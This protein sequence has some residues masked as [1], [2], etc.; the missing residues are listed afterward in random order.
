MY[1]VTFILK[2]LSRRPTRTALTVLGLAVA[3]GSMIALLGISHNFTAAAIESFERRGVDLIV[4]PGGQADQLSG[5]I[6]EWVV[7]RVRGWE[8]IDGVAAAIV[9]VAEMWRRDRKPDEQ[10]APSMQ[11]MVQAWAPDNFVFD[12]LEILEGHRL[13]VGDT[14]K[15][16]LGNIVADNLK[17]GVGDTVTILG[18]PWEVV[19]VF[20]SPTVF[21]SGSVV[22][23]L[24]DY[25]TEVGAEGKVT[26]FSVRVK[27]SAAN[28]DAA[29]TA[30]REKLLDLKDAKGTP[31]RLSAESP[32]QYAEN[33]SHLKIARAMAWLVSLIAVVIGVISM[34]N[35]MAMSV[36]ERTQEIGILRAVGWPRGRV[37]RMVLGEAILLGLTAALV[38][39]AGAVAAT[40][41]LSYMPKVNGFI[42]GGIAPEVI[43]QG[44]GM[45]VLVGL[46]GGAYPAFRAARLLPTEAI[47]HD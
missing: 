4:I 24:T 14:G 6:D 30:V 41:S 18:K 1:F 33:S 17:K 23:L 28:P 12:E 2:N 47:R 29:V 22:M 8:E 31:V 9:D 42:A 21:E 35:T 43:L 25:Q 3:V 11:V 26:G 10:S 32:R 15:V 16:M 19:A 46:L 7:D 40:Y 27:K 36:L 45:T 39:A 13:H 44:L 34:M 20:K 38:G 37:V 5:K